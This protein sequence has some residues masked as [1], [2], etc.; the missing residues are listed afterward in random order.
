[1]VVYF[2]NNSTTPVSAEA[3]QEIMNALEVYGNASSLHALGVEARNLID[4]ARRQIALSLGCCDEEIILTSGG[5][6]SNNIAI[7]G[8]LAAR[9]E[10]KHIITSRIEHPSIMGV[11]RFL[12][13]KGYRV[14]WI[15]VDKSGIVDLDELGAELTGETALVSIMAANNEIGTIQPVENVVSIVKG[16]SSE[17]AVHT[18]AVQAFGK[19]KFSCPQVGADMMS[20]SS[21]KINGPK[22]VGALYLKKGLKID[23]VYHGGHQE[24]NIR[25]GTEN[26]QAIAGFGKAAEIIGGNIKGKAEKMWMLRER[27]REG[28]LQNIESAVMNGHPADVLP[29][30]LSVSFKNIEGES[31]LM[32]LDMEGIC[33]STG[34]A[35]S[36]GS[37]EPSH[38]LTAI[39]LEPGYAQGTIRFSLGYQN[40]EEEVDYVLDKLPPIIKRLREMS[41]LAG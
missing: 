38:V 3:K 30:T 20:F 1:M 13:E 36:S 9:P 22:G 33:V 2:D 6:E 17:I 23:S 16:F 26:V 28:I 19:I 34:S 37:T 24:K 29:N 27:L 11:F 5:T 4:N 8:L 21:H 40:T 15:S 14:S 41:P 7:L 18:D 10:K 32:M 31:I 25:S 39:E 35:C 12:S